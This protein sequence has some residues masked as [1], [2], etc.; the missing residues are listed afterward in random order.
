M[1]DT[2][3]TAEKLSNLFQIFYTKAEAH[4][5]THVSALSTRQSRRA[6]PSPSMSSQASGSTKDSKKIRSSS[7]KDTLASPSVASEQQMLT[8][9]EISDR[10]KAR[11]LLDRKKAALEEAV[12]RRVCERV[13][14]KI[15]RHRSTLDEVRDEKL[16]SRTAALALV[17][18]G[19]NDLGIKFETLG[20]DAD[21][22]RLGDWISKARDGLLGMNNEKCPLGKL[23]HLASTHKCIV[24][25]LTE[26][27][28]S[29]SSADE[30]LPTL[31]YT[32]ITTPPKGS[33]VISN[34]HFIQRF[35]AAGKIDG[36]AAYL[37]VNLEAAITFLETVDLA[38]LRSDEPLGGPPKLASRPATP[39]DES[40]SDSTSPSGPP[41]DPSPQPPLLNHPLQPSSIS[42]PSETISPSHQ[43]KLS[44]LFQPSTGALGAAGDAVRTTADQGFKTIGNSLDTSFQFLFGRL[45]EHKVVADRLSGEETMTVPKTLEDARK[46][47]EPKTEELDE[48]SAY[49]IPADNGLGGLTVRNAKPSDNIL[50]AFAGRKQS[51]DPSVDS[52]QSASS[53]S[54]RVAFAAEK[55]PSQPP[56]AGNAA[57]ESVLNLGNTLNPLKGFSG[58]GVRGFGRA[59][60]NSPSATT[61]SGP[62]QAANADFPDSVDNTSERDTKKTQHI[63]PPIER[64][65]NMKN[66]EDLRVGEITELLRDY[67]RLAGALK[68]LESF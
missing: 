38:S 25:L 10:R 49:L 21:E 9:Q 36:E 35:R 27:H 34:L 66:A 51:R 6:S 65:M 42:P 41:E 60:S 64:F 48:P 14:N 43:R 1:H 23:Q 68:D 5:A 4:I 30:I 44:N 28:Q 12:E 11:R 22:S 39:H 45:K 24:D 54:K 17:G 59:S 55:A 29:S 53:S 47:V 63:Q 18:I 33:N 37:L 57:V 67:R 56:Y 52:A 16:R 3:P 15:W 13:Y 50:S 58:F 20:P 31:I 2:P 40:P 62:T 61:T 32:L 8:P 26:L 7:S 46:L 19:L